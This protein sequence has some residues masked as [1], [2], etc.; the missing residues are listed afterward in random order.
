[1]KVISKEEVIEILDII[2]DRYTP[3]ANNYTLKNKD[4]PSFKKLY[5]YINTPPS[6]E[7]QLV[8][9][10]A[11]KDSEVEEA[12]EFFDT[13]LYTMGNILENP[14]YDSGHN[15]FEYKYE[16]IKPLLNTITKA[17]SDKDRE[18]DKQKL[19]ITLIN[20]TKKQYKSKLS[21]IEEVVNSD[22]PMS[23]RLAKVR[24]LLRSDKE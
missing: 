20:M 12:I 5:Q 24:E 10:N 2:G 21:A 17:L 14:I 19:D 11:L 15:K 6:L 7:G 3:A 23:Y 9:T 22:N 1:M 16:K 18:I 13:I 8:G 4:F